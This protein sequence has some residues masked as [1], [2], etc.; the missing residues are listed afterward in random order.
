[1]D[2][3]IQELLRKL[4]VDDGDARILGEAETVLRNSKVKCRDLQ[5]GERL[6]S[7]VATDLALGKGSDYSFFRPR[8][9]VGIVMQSC[10]F[11]VF[12]LLFPPRL[13]VQAYIAVYTRL[14]NVLGDQVAPKGRDIEQLAVKFAGGSVERSRELLQKYSGDERGGR[15]PHATEACRRTVTAEKRDLLNYTTPE[16]HA[17]A[18]L[19]ATVEAGVKVQAVRKFVA[20]EVKMNVQDL[21]KICVDVVRKCG[22]ADNEHVAKAF[23]MTAPGSADRGQRSEGKRK[24][25]LPAPAGGGCNSDGSPATATATTR[26][27]V[28]EGSSPLFRTPLQG[29][30][31]VLPWFSEVASS[32]L[33]L[34]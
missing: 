9:S 34:G 6:R 20:A 28:P 21:D 23:R 15:W 29:G 14:R 1:M 13:L 17:A 7:Y 31:C 11:G 18:F 24:Q 8:L 32:R 19:V 30:A 33:G 12:R 25:V 10:F 4:E 26:L 2:I 22:L 16:Y 27:G 3:N 5:N